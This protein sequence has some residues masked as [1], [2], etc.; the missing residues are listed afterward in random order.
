MISRA[1][2]AQWQSS[3]I[4]NRRLSVR[5]GSSA[6]IFFKRKRLAVYQQ[7]VFFWLKHLKLPLGAARNER[8]IGLAIEI[9]E[10]VD[11]CYIIT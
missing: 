11:I 1:D 2:V 6:P 10:I 3:G 5:L 4:V 8:Q 9:C 7:G